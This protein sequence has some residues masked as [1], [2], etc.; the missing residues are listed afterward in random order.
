MP[1][2]DLVA[3]EELRLHLLDDLLALGRV[4]RYRLLV[5][6]GVSFGVIDLGPVA[7]RFSSRELGEGRVGIVD[8]NSDRPG[9]K[10]ELAGV[11]GSIRG[12]VV[13]DVDLEVPA[14]GLS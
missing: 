7:N 10:V 4:Q 11:G 2:N 6:Q 12:G 13:L 9:N 8:R 3:V 5:E 1:N 14:K